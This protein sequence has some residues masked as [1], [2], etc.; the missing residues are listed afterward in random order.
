MGLSS[1][2]PRSKGLRAQGQGWHRSSLLEGLLS[3]KPLCHPSQHGHMLPSAPSPSAAGCLEPS[4]LHTTKLDLFLCTNPHPPTLALCPEPLSQPSLS[5]ELNQCISALS[6]TYTRAPQRPECVG[7]RCSGQ[8]YVLQSSQP[9]ASGTLRG[10]S[11]QQ[12]AGALLKSDSSRPHL[13]CEDN[14]GGSDTAC[15]PSRA[16]HPLPCSPAGARGTCHCDQARESSLT[17]GHLSGWVRVR[18]GMQPIW[19]QGVHS[20]CR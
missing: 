18:R 10:T 17:P 11:S 16:P 4:S 6:P 20:L 12:T 15:V 19:P 3:M 13:P 7:P 14:P 9:A 8:A 1:P 2:A 5:E